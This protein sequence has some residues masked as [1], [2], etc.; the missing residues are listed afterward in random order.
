MLDS[1]ESGQAPPGQ[2]SSRIRLWR[3]SGVGVLVLAGCTLLINYAMYREW[4]WSAY[5]SRLEA[6]GR[7][8]QKEGPPQTRQELE[9]PNH[10]KLIRIGGT[11]GW[12]NRGDL[13]AFSDEQPFSGG[14]RAVLMVR[15]GSRFQVYDLE[16]GP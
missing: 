6:C 15:E 8:F 7:D 5:P 11:P 9:A 1:P 2:K 3:W 16:G 12:F 10:E 13:W 14:C 4:P